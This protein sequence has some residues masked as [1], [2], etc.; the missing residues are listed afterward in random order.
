MR[1]GG[2]FRSFLEGCT[3]N[4]ESLA[5]LRPGTSGG[6]W[7]AA[8][9]FTVDTRPLTGQQG[10]DLLQRMSRKLAPSSGWGMFALPPLSGDKQTSGEQARASSWPRLGSLPRG[11]THTRLKDDRRRPARLRLILESRHFRAA[12]VVEIDTQLMQKDP[13]AIPSL[14]CSFERQWLDLEV[15]A[16]HSAARR[17]GRTGGRLLRQL[18]DHGFG[19]DQERRD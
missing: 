18:S 15:H 5:R 14:S 17:H 2:R 11:H 19:G 16:A 12:I 8:T 4:F 7:E 3:H 10:R 9:L 13:A 1:I 6:R